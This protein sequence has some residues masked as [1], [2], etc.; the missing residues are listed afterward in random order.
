MPHP[1]PLDLVFSRFTG[2]VFPAIQTSIER[3]GIEPTDRDAF[4][5]LPDAVTLLHDLRPDEGLGEGMDYL[6]AL[7][8]HAYLAWEAGSLTLSL[9]S[10]R[11]EALL[12]ADDPAT[13]DLAEAPR[14]YY[15]EF[16][17]RQ[18]WASVVDDEAVEPLDGCFVHSTPGGS[19]RVLG[20]FGFRPE[21]AGFSEV[22]AIG[23][24]P[25]AL[26][27]PDGTPLFS[28]TLGAG[29]LH[30]LVGGEELLELGWRTLDHARDAWARV[31]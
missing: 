29:H 5:L 21:R 7:V 10:D 11:L 23:P 27:R 19:L 9:P 16:P 26:R 18:V 8:H 28:S 31:A 4:L 12:H 24:R 1:T 15:V 2:T 17:G 13:S 22:E 3:D 14:A 25:G 20:I 6:V 30:S